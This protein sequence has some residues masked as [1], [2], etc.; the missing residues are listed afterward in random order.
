MTYKV[1][2]LGCGR[3]AP[4]HAK[5]LS[6]VEGLDLCA[7]CDIDETKAIDLGLEC[8]VKH[9]LDMEQMMEIL[10]VG[11]GKLVNQL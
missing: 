7:V 5:V 4:H 6:E 8:G 10:L 9:Y 1:A 2:L 11:N 3:I